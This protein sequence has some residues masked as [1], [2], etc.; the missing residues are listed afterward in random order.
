MSL[1][2]GN[3]A[4]GY[5]AV[6]PTVPELNLDT[7]ARVAAIVVVLAFALVVMIPTG[8]TGAA[9]LAVFAAAIATGE[10][11]WIAVDDDIALPTSFAMFPV[12]AVA[13]GPAAF[14]VTV[15]AGSIAGVLLV[16]TRSY[17]R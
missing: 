7:A 5:R 3:R 9:T 2:R 15:A 16:A 13:A 14:G 4:N 8:H 6:G 17:S 1:K 12:V 11:L 10:L